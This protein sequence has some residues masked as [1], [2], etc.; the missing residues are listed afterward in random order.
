MC[1]RWLYEKLPACYLL[2]AVGMIVL[3][4]SPLLWLAGALLFVAGAASWMMRS[5]YRRT[6]LVIFPTKRWFQPE[7]LYEA[8]PFIWLTL[9]LLLSHLPDAM[10]LV[11]LL[12]CAWACRCLWVRSHY[13]HHAAG[14]ASHLRRDPARRRRVRL[15]R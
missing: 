7:W 12:P 6:D 10:A 15:L 4:D 9:G 3:T 13:R 5:S 11:A 2:T 14:L 8:Q 1:P